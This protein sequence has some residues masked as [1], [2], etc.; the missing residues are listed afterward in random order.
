MSSINNKNIAIKE[1]SKFSADH[2]FSSKNINEQKELIKKPKSLLRSIQKSSL[3]H[4]QKNFENS[5]NEVK[6]EIKFETRMES[7][8]F[9]SGLGNIG[10]VDEVK[11]NN[12]NISS[13]Y[14]S[15]KQISSIEN[16]FENIPLPNHYL[17]RQ[18]AISKTMRLSF[19]SRKK[20]LLISKELIKPS[21]GG[22]KELAAQ[23]TLF[24]RKRRSKQP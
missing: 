11:V 22:N 1:K 12:K 3:K 2:S 7:N 16:S 23:K 8:D 9:N 21:E 4:H 15:S 5:V 18:T 10:D 6:N 13:N 20:S 19:L 17:R 24:F 14:K